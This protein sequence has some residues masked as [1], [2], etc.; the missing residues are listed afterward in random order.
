MAVSLILSQST[1]TV[2]G[3]ALGVTALAVFA[4]HKL[5]LVFIVVEVT[6]ITAIPAACLDVV[7]VVAVVIALV[8]GTT[9]FGHSLRAVAAVTR[10]PEDILENFALDSM[11]AFPLGTSSFKAKV[12]RTCLLFNVGCA[13]ATTTIA[14]VGVFQT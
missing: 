11:F 5:I 7:V 8:L 1:T 14:T 6:A 2:D 12:R 13:L 10:A 3:C 9:A 4:V